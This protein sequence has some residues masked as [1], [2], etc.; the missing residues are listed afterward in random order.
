MGFDHRFSYV[1]HPS[2]LA[3]MAEEKEDLLRSRTWQLPFSDLEAEHDVISELCALKPDFA[4][5]TLGDLRVIREHY[6]LLLGKL[7]ADMRQLF[8]RIDQAIQVHLESKGVAFVQEFGTAP[9]MQL[10]A[11][12]LSAMPVSSKL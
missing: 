12:Q 3:W 4:T 1:V 11:V 10:T 5:C 6:D 9:A 7:D 8:E 2:M